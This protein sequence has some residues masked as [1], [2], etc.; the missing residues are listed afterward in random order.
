MVQYISPSL[1]TGS[2]VNQT[3]AIVTRREWIFPCGR[4]PLMTLVGKRVKLYIC[5]LLVC[6]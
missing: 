1:G 4:R 2:I 5:L 6:V 3:A